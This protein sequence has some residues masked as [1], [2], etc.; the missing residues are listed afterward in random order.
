MLGPFDQSMFDCVMSTSPKFLALPYLGVQ[1]LKKKN[2][3]AWC[4]HA[5]GDEVNAPSVASHVDGKYA[6]CKT[7]FED[8]MSTP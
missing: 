8:E 7:N 6:V 1:C 4:V 5:D 3:S 2:M